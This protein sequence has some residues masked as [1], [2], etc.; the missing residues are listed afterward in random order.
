MRGEQRFYPRLV[1]RKLEDGKINFSPDAYY[2]ITGGT[3]G[4]GLATTRWMIEKGRRNLVLCSRRGAEGISPEILANF[5]SS[6]AEV[7]LKKLDITDAEKLHAVLDE[8]RSKYPI[9]GIF[10]IAGTLDDTTLLRLTPESF[11]YVLAPKVK[12]TWLLHQ[13]T[14]ND[15]LEFFVCYTSA[16]SLIG[17]TGRANAAQANCL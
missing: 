13:L 11:N 7:T 9:R 2:L 16:V 1:Q 12:G 15:P 6:G 3:G 10:H 17:W 5:S 14:L 8:C 4:L